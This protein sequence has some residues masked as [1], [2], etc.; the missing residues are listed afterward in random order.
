MIITN[1]EQLNEAL[2][3]LAQQETVAYDTETT[4]LNTRKDAV[5]GFGISSAATGYYF[6]IYTYTSGKLQRCRWNHATEH[7]DAMYSLLSAL[8]TKK[9]L[10][11][12][13]SFD[14]RF[15]KYNLGVDLLPALHADVLL[16]K[17]TC[18]E[19]YPLGLKDIAKDLYGQ[20]ATKE[21][22][23]MQASIKANGGTAKQYFKASTE[24]IAKYCVQ[25]CLLTFKIYNHYSRI[26]TKDGLDTFYYRDEVLPLY[27]EVTIPMEEHG[28]LLDL[29]LLQNSLNEITADLAALE[30]SIQGAVI[31]HLELFTTWF[32]NKDYP[33]TTFASKKPSAW[34]KKYET[35][36]QAWAVE[37][38]KGFMFNLQSKH[39]LKKVFFDTLGETPLSRTPKGAPQVDEEF[40]EQM[41]Q[42][43]DWC[44][45]LIVFNKLT[46]IKGTYIERFLEEQED[47]YFYPSFQ[48]HRTVSGRYAGDLQQLPRPLPDGGLV[49][50]Y[51]NRIRAFFIASEG[52]RLMSADYEQLEPRVF[53][54]VSGDKALAAIFNTGQ[55]FYSEIARMTEGLT[56][57]NKQQRQKAKSY[58]LGIPYGMTGYKLKFEIGCTDDEADA[59]VAKYLSAFP[60]LQAWMGATKVYARESGAIRSELGR[61]RRMPQVPRIWNKYYSVIENDLDLWKAFNQHPG[62]YAAAKADRKLYKNLINNANNFQIQSMAASI[63]NRASIAIARQLIQNGLRARIVAQV[64]DELVLHVP[65]NE[66]E[67]VSELVKNT[68]ENCTLLSVPLITKPQFGTNYKEC[69]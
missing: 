68:M 50:K 64:H 9:L 58:A 28:V 69:K 60:Q 19:D 22:E 23:E 31:P 17:H 46:K 29:P 13:A 30:Q 5:I 49:A 48:Q 59:L 6:P 27:K 34:T 54:H 39:H 44:A 15:T 2:A 11:F 56:E 33:L 43:Y 65:E 4:G 53:C 63:M 14:A 52:A 45:D 37:N 55:D 42:K 35:Q 41:A 7:T 24:T 67:Q 32:L 12:N 3:W 16:L 66:T 26:L 36:M 10:M 62:V 20:D 1:S 57:V 21:K 61:I 51:T 25:D 40:L 47:G 8:R 18:D 38:P